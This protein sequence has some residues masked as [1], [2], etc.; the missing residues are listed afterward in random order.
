MQ[1]D[2]KQHHQEQSRHLFEQLER[3]DAELKAAHDNK[4]LRRKLQ[5]DK[6]RLGRQF[7]NHLMIDDMGWGTRRMYS[8]RGREV[9][10]YL[11]IDGVPKK[12]KREEANAWM[13]ARGIK[14]DGSAPS[15]WYEVR[16]ALE[17]RENVPDHRFGLHIGWT[18]RIRPPN[19]NYLEMIE[20]F[21]A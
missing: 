7:A 5:R 20:F 9:E 12:N 18:V 14:W 2:Q 10:P 3:V 11:H 19:S 1:H 15:L 17:K 21:G 6:A 4:P 13:Q 16:S 8:E